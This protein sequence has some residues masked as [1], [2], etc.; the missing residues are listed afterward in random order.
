MLTVHVFYLLSL[1][2]TNTVTFMKPLLPLLACLALVGC[3]DIFSYHPY[4]TRFSGE[5]D[6]NNHN[7]KRIETECRDKDTLHFVFTGDT[8]EW[9]ADTRDMVKSINARDSIDFI[10]HGGD[11]TDAGLTEEFIWQREVLSKLNKPYVALI[12]NHDF[13]GTG[14][15]V[16]TKMY[17][18]LDFSFIAARVKFVCLNT[19]ATEYDYMAAVPNF[20]FMEEQLTADSSM[21]D[22]T[23][24]CMHACPYSDQFNNNVAKA[25]EHYINLFPGLICCL[26][27]HDHSVSAND[28]Y[29][30]G[31]I[32]YG[33]A[34][35]VHRTYLLFTITPTDY[36]YE[37]VSY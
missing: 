13:L 12:G 28:I 15:E 1:H 27:A 3:E 17:G 10:I 2:T 19:N 25:F 14:D 30:D 20:D 31:V 11:L 34:S 33:C 7:I 37:V 16:Y 6:I 4:D 21:F 23:I 18:K 36:K 35:A 9:Y 8:H 5:T 22:R 29:G 32:Y 26:K 24:V